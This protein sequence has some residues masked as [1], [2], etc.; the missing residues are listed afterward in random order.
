MLTA[1]ALTGP[2]L[3]IFTASDGI[4]DAC[5]GSVRLGGSVLS[6]NLQ[7]IQTH[8]SLSTRIPRS[9]GEGKGVALCS[10]EKDGISDLPSFEKVHAF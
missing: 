5:L 8:L 3:A 9:P 6:L 4:S 1:S 10:P 7:T 2:I